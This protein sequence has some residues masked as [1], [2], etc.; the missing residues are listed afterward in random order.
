MFHDLLAPCIGKSSVDVVLVLWA[1]QWRHNGHNGV[2]NHQLHD[3]LLNRL[4]R[5]RSKKTSKSVSLAFLRGIPRW[6][7]NSPQKWPVTRKMFPFDDVIISLNENLQHGKRYHCRDPSMQVFNAS[8]SVV[9]SVVECSTLTLH[10]CVVYGIRPWTYITRY[11]IR[12]ATFLFHCGFIQL[13][14]VIT[15]D[16]L[17][18]FFFTQAALC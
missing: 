4:F 13:F 7:V 2:S 1:L 9:P 6:P 14:S 10:Y 5:R 18:K 11:K 3:C 16:H 15:C 8:W 17:R 12:G